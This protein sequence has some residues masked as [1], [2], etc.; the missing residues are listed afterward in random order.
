[1]T[2]LD[3]A[4]PPLQTKPRRWG[5]SGKGHPFTLH[6]TSDHEA[7]VSREG[8]GCG[9]VAGGADAGG[10]IGGGRSLRE[11]VVYGGEGLGRG[12]K[13]VWLGEGDT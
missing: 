13:D 2:L 11:R 6:P 1:M 7:Q 9:T 3:S 10:S 4:D 5:S 8:E 12:V